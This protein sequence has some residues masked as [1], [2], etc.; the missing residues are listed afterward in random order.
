MIK[1]SDKT[2]KF[3]KSIGTFHLLDIAFKTKSNLPIKMCVLQY[4]SSKFPDLIISIAV[5]ETRKQNNNA[6]ES[7]IRVKEKTFKSMN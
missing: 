2:P 3:Y 1:K 4:L 6:D 5:F 7:Q